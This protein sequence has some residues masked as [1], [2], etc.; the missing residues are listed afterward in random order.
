MAIT[1]VKQTLKQMV[2]FIPMHS[3]RA[4]VLRLCGYV[5]GEEVY[6]GPDFII[7]DRPC[8]RGMVYLGDR[9]A[10]SPRVTLVVSSR[11]NN[12]RIAPYLPVR[13][14]MITI[15]NDAWL[16]TGTV[17]LPGIRVG[18]GAIVGANAVV[19]RDVPPYTIV[20]GVPART[21]GYVQV[22]W[23]THPDLGTH[24]QHEPLP[25]SKEPETQL[26]TERQ[27]EGTAVREP[28]PTI[29]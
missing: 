10:I 23:Y 22:P 1:F 2:R 8:D 19:T 13:N 25:S 15:E 28:S 27:G 24:A 29:T 12:S 7:M 16:G 14:D 6:I 20:A 11:P 18:E 9:V 4:R 17:V 26:G 5:L 21:I 3:L